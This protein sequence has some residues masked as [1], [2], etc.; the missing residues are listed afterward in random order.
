MLPIALFRWD[1]R[2]TPAVRIHGPRHFNT[3]LLAFGTL[4]PMSAV[5]HLMA[6][7][8]ALHALQGCLL[9]CGLYC[10]VPSIVQLLT[11]CSS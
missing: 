9:P 2:S 5:L 10:S 7:S 6:C 11:I 1:F 3:C 4:R 8:V